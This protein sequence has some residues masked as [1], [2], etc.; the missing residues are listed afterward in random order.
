[1]TDSM[2]GNGGARGFKDNFLVR[3][4][5]VELD[6]RWYHPWIRKHWRRARDKADVTLWTGLGLLTTDHSLLLCPWRHY[7]YPLGGGEGSAPC[8]F[9]LHLRRSLWDENGLGVRSLF[10]P[11]SQPTLELWLR[12]CLRTQLLSSEMGCTCRC[13][14]QL[15][16]PLRG[17]NERVILNEADVRYHLRKC[18]DGNSWRLED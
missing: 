17:E 10:V 18:I 7:T 5:P 14:S 15:T 16:R 11:I 3:F 6:G 13:P 9:G 12:N 1:M 4:W 2:S 8:M